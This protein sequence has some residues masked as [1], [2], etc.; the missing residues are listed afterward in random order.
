MM[1]NNVDDDD[2][3]DDDVSNHLVLLFSVQYLL[4]HG[5]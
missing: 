3:H 1:H 2:N 5:S 4:K